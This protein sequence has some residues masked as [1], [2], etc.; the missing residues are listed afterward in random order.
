MCEFYVYLLIDPFNNRPFYIGKGKGDRAFA[1]TK[2]W[3]NYNEDKL[4]YIKSIRMLGQEPEVR[5]LKTNLTSSEA[6]RIENFLIERFSFCLIN[7]KS[8][9]PDKTGVLLTDDHKSKI[10]KALSGRTLTQE[11]KQKIGC[12]NSFVP[13]YNKGGSYEDNS[14]SRNEGSKN[15]RAKKVKVGDR[16]FNCMKHAYEFYGVSKQTFKKRFDYQ[17]MS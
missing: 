8:I 12:S 9:P 10:S 3:A 5:F 16:V 13:N 17:L 4:N 15:P 11:H 6:L 2:G 7:K 14:S 1:H